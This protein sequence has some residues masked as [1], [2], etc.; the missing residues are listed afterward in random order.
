MDEKR[1][2]EALGMWFA[3]RH[4]ESVKIFLEEADKFYFVAATLDILDKEGRKSTDYWGDLL[5]TYPY[6]F[7]Q[8]PLCPVP[9]EGI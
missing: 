6:E 9:M 8:I 4:R 2:Q 1:Y 5:A 7:V 3:G